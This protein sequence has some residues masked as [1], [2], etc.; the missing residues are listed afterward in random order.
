LATQNIPLPG[1]KHRPGRV[2][3]VANPT[4]YALL[5]ALAQSGYPLAGVVTSFLRWEG[6]TISYAFRIIVILLGIGISGQ[7]ILRGRGRFLPAIVQ[8]FLILYFV[9]LYYDTF[10]DPLPF[11]DFAFLFFPGVVLAPTLAAAIAIESYDETRYALATFWVGAIACVSIT[12]LDWSGWGL[13]RL[14]V[15]GRLSFDALNPITVGFTGLFTLLAIFTLWK[16]RPGLIPIFVVA[17]FFAV[18]SLVEAASRGPVAAGAAAFALIALARRN[19]TLFAILI[20][21]GLYAVLFA[22]DSSLKL[23]ARFEVVGTDTDMSSA[24]RLFFMQNA[25][26]Q[27]WASPLFGHA[28]VETVTYNSP[29]HLIIESFLALG[30]VGAVLMAIM[31]VRM[32]WHA[33]LLA[34]GEHEFLAMIIACAFVNANLSAALW[35]SADFWIPLILG[36]E[37]ARRIKAARRNGAYSV[38][39]PPA[40]ISG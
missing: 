18:Y 4:M 25:I 33:W 10:I 14:E 35:S 24:E 5:L 15:T 31:F 40:A 1:G 2:G 12:L 21:G 36:I 9:R 16:K 11:A 39:M 6:S 3:Q 34:K 23:L 7:A 37:M 28:Y 13:S 26:E 30:V 38:Q 17:G 22:S 20:L 8:I 29:H 27:A 19:F 32:V